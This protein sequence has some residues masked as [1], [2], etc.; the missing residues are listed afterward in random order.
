MDRGARWP[1]VHGAAQ[2]GHDR[3]HVPGYFGTTP[4]GLMPSPLEDLVGAPDLVSYPASSIAVSARMEES[5][6]SSLLTYLSHHCTPVLPLSRS[7]IRNVSG[8][9]MV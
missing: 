6:P 8:V 3:V 4:V 9:L 7:K 1:T 2:S 5:W